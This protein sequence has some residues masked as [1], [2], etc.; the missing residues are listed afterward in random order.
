MLTNIVLGLYLYA[1]SNP[2]VTTLLSESESPCYL[3]I[4][5]EDAMVQTTIFPDDATII[6][7]DG[8]VCFY[9]IS[10]NSFRVTISTNEC[11]SSGCTLTF[12]RTGNVEVDKDTFT[13]IIQSRFIVKDVDSEYKTNC[14]CAAD[15]GGA[16]E[17][18]L[19]TDELLD[20]TYKIKLGEIQI[21]EFAI[22][23]YRNNICWITETTA[24]PIPSHAPATETKIPVAYPPPPIETITPTVDPATPGG[25]RR[26]Y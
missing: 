18:H 3:P 22:P 8:R 4:P 2:Q 24:T 11:F 5:P 13:V 20:G 17:I 21:G 14:E 19:K 15:C 9:S 26:D 6:E 12:E 7:D 25:K 1:C 10:E 16:G 23:F